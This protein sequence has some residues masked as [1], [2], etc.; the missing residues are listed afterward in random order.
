ML[1]K[2]KQIRLRHF[3]YGNTGAYY[4]TICTNGRKRFLSVVEGENV[5]LTSFGN[6]VKE[7][8]EKTPEMRPNISLG[9]YV[10]M[11]NHIHLVLFFYDRTAEKLEDVKDKPARTFGGSHGGSLSSVIAHFKSAVTSRIRKEYG[12]PEAVIWQKG[13][14]EHII[15]DEKDLFR[16]TDYIITNPINWAVDAENPDHNP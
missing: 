7:E 16:I 6:I 11:P 5:K 2:R 8:I 4:V 15:R 3:D 14:F 13:F 10:I 12:K 9:E 1:P